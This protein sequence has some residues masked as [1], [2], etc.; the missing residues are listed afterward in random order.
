LL[1][2]AGIAVA[3]LWALVTLCTAIALAVGLPLLL[4]GYWLPNCRRLAAGLFL[5]LGVFGWGLGGLLIAL[6]VL[7]RH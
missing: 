5:S 6:A 7:I 2:D 3:T 4:L 1:T